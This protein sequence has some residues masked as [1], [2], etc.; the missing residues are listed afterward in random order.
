LIYVGMSGFSYPEWIPDFY[1]KGTKRQ[2]LL[3]AYAERFD[4]V[5]LNMT[6][7]RDVPE[8]T[9]TKWRREVPDHFRFAAKAHQ[10]ITHFRRLVGAKENVEQFVASMRPLGSTLGVILFQTRSNLKFD[11]DVLD[12]FCSELP[13]GPA[14]AFEPRHDS[15]AT[16][17][18]NDILRKHDV[19]LCLNDEIFDPS[20]YA[21]TAPLAY[22]RFHGEERYDA[23]EL[24]RR[25]SIV[26][27]LPKDVDVYAVFA[28]EDDPR[29]IRPALEFRELVTGR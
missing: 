12:T 4:A 28:H 15:F 17:E 29:C 16:D 6:F 5:E 24:E 1:P 22:F 23:G 21:L 11:P 14:Y 27:E 26:R 8:S 7:R 13:S 18:C 2:R 20:T 3:E 9:V 25:A 10:R 19:A